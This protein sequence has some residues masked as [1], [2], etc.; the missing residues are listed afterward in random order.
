MAFKNGTPTVGTTSTVTGWKGGLSATILQVVLVP[1]TNQDNC[2][3][4]Y[5]VAFI[6]VRM[7]CTGLL[8]VGG[9][10]VCQNDSGDPPIVNGVLT[11]VVS[12]GVSCAHP[13][14]LI[15]N[16][17]EELLIFN[18]FCNQILICVT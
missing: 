16:G 3:S 12:W 10:G 17:L 14:F 15:D 11:D 1:I 7:I 18:M 5:G 6:T 13:G 4:A 9:R 2:S 8:G